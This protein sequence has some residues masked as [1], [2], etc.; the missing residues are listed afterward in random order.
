MR[1]ATANRLP[2]RSAHSHRGGDAP[3]LLLVEDNQ[4]NQTVAIAMLGVAQC[5][6]IDV[7]NDGYAALARLRERSYDLI[8]MDVQMP[9]MDGLEA[10]RH[11]RRLA[12][13][14]SA[15]PIIGMTAHAFAED[16]DQCLNAGMD[17]YISKP[18]NRA[19]LLE[20][21]SH[22]LANKHLAAARSR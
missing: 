16:R 6:E 18:V 9:E 15:L 13:G 4:V 10:T 3:R 5:Y 20:K 11:I 14:A 22:W 19:Q 2:N 8:L 7:A 1:D 21:V 12:T 17:D